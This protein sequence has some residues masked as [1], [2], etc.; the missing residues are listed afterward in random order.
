M[1]NQVFPKCLQKTEWR[2]RSIKS[3][4]VRWKRICGNIIKKFTDVVQAN[5]WNQLKAL[6][7]KSH[8]LLGKLSMMT[9]L[10]R[11][12][13]STVLNLE[14]KHPSNTW[15]KHEGG[16]LLETSTTIMNENKIPHSTNCDYEGFSTTLLTSD[17]QPNWFQFT[18]FFIITIKLMIIANPSTIAFHHIMILNFITDM[19]QFV[20]RDLN[21]LTE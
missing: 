7:L 9:S 21:C 8:Y 11:Q 17:D 2:A 15:P 16:L 10:S 19:L 13:F 5:N 3:S 1:W 4:K 14:C 12:Y 6:F 18:I 20:C